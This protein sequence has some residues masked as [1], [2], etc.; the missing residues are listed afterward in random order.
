[1]IQMEWQETVT[2]NK[3]PEPAAV[4][5]V[6]SAFAVNIIHRAWLSFLSSTI[7]HDA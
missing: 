2:P 6:S 3:W 1:M 7:K 5:A 4:G